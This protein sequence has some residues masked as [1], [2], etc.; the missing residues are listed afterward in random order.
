MLKEDLVFTCSIVKKLSAY[1]SY[2]KFLHSVFAME[3]SRR[4]IIRTFPKASISLTDLEPGTRH[5]TYYI[6]G[7]LEAKQ[8]RL[9]KL[10]KTLSFLLE[11]QHDSLC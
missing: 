9:A 1:I 8:H 5:Y 4:F 2:F 6:A 10:S 7:V 3:P 11:L